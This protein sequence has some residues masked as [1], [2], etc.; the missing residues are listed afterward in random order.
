MELAIQQQVV[1]LQIKVHHAHF[2]EV[3]EA[4]HSAEGHLGTASQIQPALSPVD[5]EEV[6]VL[7]G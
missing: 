5:Q 1:G 6:E 4:M 7:A 2:M 3:R